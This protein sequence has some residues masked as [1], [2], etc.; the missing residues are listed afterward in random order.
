MSLTEKFKLR[1]RDI[2]NNKCNSVFGEKVSM[3]RLIV[4]DVVS[5]I[6]DNCKKFAELLAV[7]RKNIYH[8]IYVFNNAK[9]SNLKDFITN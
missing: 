7:C 1:T 2:T 4:M 6:A 5:G 9:E 3:D 8:C